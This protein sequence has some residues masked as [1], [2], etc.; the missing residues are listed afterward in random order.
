MKTLYL[1]AS[2]CFLYLFTSSLYAA[3]IYVD[4][5][6][7]GNNDGLAW[8]HAFTSLQ[9]GI[10]AW[11]AGDEIWVAEG[12]YFPDTGS[13]QTP[14]DQTASFVLQDGMSIYGGFSGTENSRD[15]ADPSV[16]FTVLSGDID[17]NDLLVG[18]GI[19]PPGVTPFYTNIQGA[20]SWHVVRMETIFTGTTTLD[21]LVI[22]GG[23]VPKTEPGVPTAVGRGGGV[24]LL[25]NYQSGT[26]RMKR[27]RVQGNHAEIE[28]GGIYAQGAQLD[29][30]ESDFINNGADDY[31]CANLRDDDGRQGGGGLFASVDDAAK[32]GYDPLRSLK[33]VTFQGNYAEFGGGFFNEYT[34]SEAP[35]RQNQL[36]ER[37]SFDTNTATFQ[38][39]GMFNRNSDPKLN[40]V[41]FTGNR[42]EPC[43][44]APTPDDPI[45][46][47]AG[48]YTTV[49]SLS[50]E[51][52]GGPVLTDVVFS[53]NDARMYNTAPA[54]PDKYEGFGG[55]MLS[56]NSNPTLNNVLASG[57]NSH[58]SGG[59]IYAYSDSVGHTITINNSTFA[60]NSINQNATTCGNGRSFAQ[61]E[62]I[63][64]YAV[65]N[66]SIFWNNEEG[67]LIY[68]PFA[69]AN[70]G[71]LKIQQSTV[72][73]CG[74][75]GAWGI[76]MSCGM[77]EGGNTDI[78]PAFVAPVS[79]GAAPT[80]AGNYRLMISSPAV[81]SGDNT[82]VPTGVTTDLDGGPRVTDGDGNGVAVV[83]KGA[84]E[85]PTG[86]P[87]AGDHTLRVKW[88]A[89]GA[90]TGLTWADA[91]PRLQD[92]LDLYEGCTGASWVDEIW[93]A[94]GVYYPDDRIGVSPSDPAA[95]RKEFS[96]NLSNKWPA[97]HGGIQIYGGFAGTELSLNQRDVVANLTVL[98]GD[99][100]QDDGT[101]SNGIVPSPDL[102]VGIN[103]VH[104]V[105]EDA[106]SCGPTP[107]DDCPQLNGFTITGGNALTGD[108]NVK[109]GQGG[110]MWVR[111]GT[112]FLELLNFQ[113]NQAYRGGGLY[114][115][116]FSTNA[117]DGFVRFESNWARTG[118]GLAVEGDSHPSFGFIT[119]QSNEAK[120]LGG[121]G[122]EVA[123]G[124]GMYFASEYAG[125]PIL[126][127]TVNFFDNIAQNSGGGL[128]TTRPQ[129]FD[130][131][132]E[133]RNIMFRRNQA[134]V[135]GGAIANEDSSPWLD[136]GWFQGNTAQ[137]EG[138]AISNRNGSNLVLYDSLI[139]GNLAGRGGGMYNL[140]SSPQL[141]NITFSGNNT[142]G[143]GSSVMMNESSSNPLVR[144]SIAWQNSSF[145]IANASGSSPVISY[146]LFQDC[147]PSSFWDI[148]CGTDGGNN[149]EL[150]D[151]SEPVFVAPIDPTTAPSIMGNYYL[152]L[153]SAAIDQGNNSLN[154]H[155]TD[156]SDVHPR[157][158]DGDGSGTATIDMG[159]YEAPVE[160]R[161]VVD[162]VTLPVG[163]PY[164]FFF[165][166]TG[167]TEGPITFALLDSDP[168]FDSGNLTPGIYSVDE[169]PDSEWDLTSAICS[170]GSPVTAIELNDG[171]T[172]VCTFQNVQR[173]H[174][175]VDII[176]NPIASP[177]DFEFQLS[178]G[179][180]GFDQAFY[181][182][183]LDSP[184]ISPPVRQGSYN[185]DQTADP[186][187]GIESAICDDG[188]DPLLSAI[189]ML[190]GDNVL[191]TYSM[192]ER[193][194]VLVDVVTYPAGS[195]HSFEF[196]LSG[197]PDGYDQLFNLAD[198]DPVYNSP[199]LRDGGYSLDV[200]AEPQ[201]ELTAASCDDGTD[202]RI[203][204]IHTDP[205]DKVLCTYVMGERFVPAIPTASVRVL[206]ILALLL[207]LA[208]LVR[209]RRSYP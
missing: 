143:S 31:N 154:D 170:D 34:T 165:E 197:G 101:D 33:D 117:L 192:R 78:D 138:G 27:V 144:N 124:G 149:I 71:T 191:C 129:A 21:G 172:V 35:R 152:A 53:G 130:V 204:R 113:G 189:I 199:P 42:I 13:T 94:K 80:Q 109:T 196:Q 20:N 125:A 3:T 91:L 203:S 67:P 126:M 179:P 200:T 178:G 68:D 62:N 17:K 36:L 84:Y 55:A 46:G 58:N 89:T 83:E 185:L 50:L 49:S 47:G 139:S 77:D 4:V 52:A 118:G 96:F 112:S 136:Q 24:R 8:Q 190:P 194:H 61:G 127:N 9:D 16:Q 2:F 207:L 73:G 163:S 86:C 208:G 145:I 186:E 167:A 108:G 157:I 95:E 37:V 65:I 99:I 54:C 137:V 119:F 177:Y 75:S 59:A 81:D 153:N 1:S 19:A 39:G 7:V 146:S 120:L 175:L 156:L 64:H 97:S 166:L 10:A 18:S 15:E 82:L 45:W 66:N 14:G 98:S 193:I 41:S 169:Q 198:A 69:T 106:S 162:K 122:S 184:Y 142:G 140:A 173:A 79:I 43:N 51:G 76:P 70:P 116:G 104:V 29:I 209:L 160:G 188:T 131:K 205:G 12:R 22:T 28:G 110:G 102:I 147:G 134:E 176:T 90:N 40:Q 115:G 123:N 158:T 6:A 114:L 168:P 202:P 201:W 25:L 100:D 181:L 88:D 32:S 93:V 85:L 135:R 111:G 57:N 121:S 92:A 132:L 87:F 105:E 44:T 187:W 161:I 5:D 151:P 133:M 182:A 174:T 72:Q 180:D 26:F 128:Y 23:S 38:G 171:E 141:T 11:T 63:P 56:R 30:S 74:D 155:P 206:A 103:S 107:P 148:N 48:F 183:D 60:G 159:A 164:G 195:P 150:N